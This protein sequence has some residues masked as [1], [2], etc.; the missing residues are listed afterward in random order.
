MLGTFG[1]RPKGT[2]SARAAGIASALSA[3]RWKTQISTVPWDNPVDAGK[4]FLFDSVPVTNTRTTSPHLWPLAIIELI[5][6]ARRFQPDVIH[7]FKPKGFGDLAARYLR[8]HG[9]PVVV[10]MDDWEGHGGWNNALPYSY[11]QKQLFDWQERTWPPIA[12]GVTVASRSLQQRAVELGANPEHVLYLPNKLSAQR[13]SQL[14]EMGVKPYWWEENEI[15]TGSP[16]ILLYTRFVEFEPAF[17]IEVLHLLTLHVP[18]I[19]L[20]VA[21]KSADGKAEQALLQQARVAGIDDRITLIGWI[22]PEHLGWVAR[23]C[24]AALVPFDDTLINRAKCSVKLLE[25]LVT[26]AP[27]VA[28]NV[29]ENREYI[30]RYGEGRL[31]RPG[32]ADD[33]ADRLLEL[34]QGDVGRLRHRKSSPVEASW[35]ADAGRIEDL[36]KQ[37][38]HRARKGR[39]LAGR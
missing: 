28:S 11:P 36:Y 22:D 33:H 39:S 30:H 19:R 24:A 2:M 23:N 3:R 31:A 7:L 37:A 26:G 8:R 21:G 18:D 38:A 9:Y 34:I 15:D 29:G 27:V 5:Q 17:I 13:L 20:V 6:A 1:M 35:D 32:D 16:S 4:S 12:D 14:S 10:D 25:L